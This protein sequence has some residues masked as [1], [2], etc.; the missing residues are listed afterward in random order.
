MSSLSTSADICRVVECPVC[1]CQFSNKRPPKVLPCMHTF[2]KPCLRRLASNTDISSVA[3]ATLLDGYNDDV[4][5]CYIMSL[6]KPIR[7]MY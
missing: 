1:L 7:C 4:Q 5:V 2:C 6:C 3:M